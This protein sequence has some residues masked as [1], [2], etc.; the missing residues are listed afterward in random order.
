MVIPIKTA[1]K[2][3]AGTTRMAA[4]VFR[5]LFLWGLVAS[6]ALVSPL[7]LASTA[8]HSAFKSL[9]GPFATGPDVTKACLECHSKASDQVHKSIHWKWRAGPEK[10]DRQTG[11]VNIVNNFC[12][13]IRTNEA[14][15]TSCHAGYGMKNPKFDFASK[16]TVDCLVCHDTTGKYKKFPTLAG[17]PNYTPKEW[18]PK[19]G[20]IRPPVDLALVAKNVGKSGRNNCGSCHFFGGGGDGVKHGDLDSSLTNPPFAL[21][22]HMDAKGLNF[23]CQTCHTTKDHITAGS[24]LTMTAKDSNGIDIPGHEKGGRASCESCHAQ[25]P[26]K[27]DTSPMLNRH[28]AKVACETCHIPAYAREKKTKVFW[29]WSTAGTSKKMV[30]DDEGYVTFHPKKGNFTWERNVTPEYFWFS[31]KMNYTLVGDKTTKNADGVVDLVTLEGNAA[32]PGSR[33]W[34]FKVMRSITPRDP[35]TGQM[36]VPHL[37]GKDK[38]AFWKSFDWQRAAAAG[39]KASGQPFSGK[40]EFAKTTYLF[41]IA[42]MVAPAENAVTC[43]GCHAREGSRLAGVDGIYLPGRDRNLWVD[44]IGLALVLLTILGALGHGLLRLTGRKERNQS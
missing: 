22:V 2:Q 13:A 35:E 11:K 7:L 27:G 19:S 31:G 12:M 18:P 3:Q 29:D 25:T 8:D 16:E 9:Q 1:Q 41:P 6:A 38:D 20:K 26:H 44:R 15:C 37:F 43:V 34:P 4:L 17:H 42:H 33:I 14:R 24:R 40:I 30:K 28:V 10:D 32:D 39:M 5:R 36:I 21:D 23:S